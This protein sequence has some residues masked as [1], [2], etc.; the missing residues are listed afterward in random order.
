VKRYPLVHLAAAINDSIRQFTM[1]KT[2]DQIEPQQWILYSDMDRLI[3]NQMRAYL[4]AR[5]QRHGYDF[6]PLN[7]VQVPFGWLSLAALVL[8]LAW[9]LWIGARRNAVLLGFVL[10]ALIGNAVVCGALSNPHDRY[11]SRLIW[12]VPFALALLAA[13][14]PI[15]LRQREESGT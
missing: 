10:V 11:Q 15:A 8:S 9:M 7:R 13:Q 2:G 5:Q 14:P 3:P 12:I 1:F 6:A 4:T